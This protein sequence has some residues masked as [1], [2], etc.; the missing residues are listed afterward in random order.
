MF[1]VLS[2]SRCVGFIIPISPLCSRLS[3]CV[4]F[5]R[6]HPAPPIIVVCVPSLSG[7]GRVCVRMG[8]RVGRAWSQ[9]C[10]ARRGFAAPAATLSRTYVCRGHLN[11]RNEEKKNSFA[12]S[13]CVFLFLLAFRGVPRTPNLVFS[14]AVAR[15]FFILVFSPCGGLFPQGLCCSQFS[16]SASV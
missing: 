15:F 13:I 11:R 5:V 4:G 2:L 7:G 16:S 6:P 12:P 9:A 14:L 8:A 10:F 3:G 1:H